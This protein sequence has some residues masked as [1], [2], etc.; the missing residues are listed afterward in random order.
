MSKE[1]VKNQVFLTL[2][3]NYLLGAC[4]ALYGSISFK[5]LPA[6]PC[7]SPIIL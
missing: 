2:H 3:L 1:N 6:D 5:L 7:I 4:L